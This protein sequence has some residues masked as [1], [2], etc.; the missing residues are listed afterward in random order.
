MH[1]KPVSEIFN[2]TGKIAL[3]T[4][5]SVGIGAGIAKRFADAGADIVFTYRTHPEGAETVAE[6]IKNLGR[7]V[8]P[9]K[10]DI[11]DP[12]QIKSL[13]EQIYKKW[14]ALDILINN[15]GI[16]P[17]SDILNMTL[18]EWEDMIDI[19]LRSVFLCTQAAARQM[20]EAKK[21]GAIVNIGSIEGVNPASGHSHYTASKAGVAMFGMTAALE[22]GPYHIRV[23]TVS[24]GLIN[25]PKLPTAWPEGVAR[26]LN[27]SPL[28]R[29]GEPEDIA[30]ACLFFAS[31]AARWITGTQLLVD[32]G[33]MTCQIY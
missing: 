18:E 12:L 16:F 30:D 24:P 33:V 29:L 13:F 32:G 6:I 31:D 15:A 23:N 9:I 20:V 11:A 25:S 1:M 27:R 7:K 4:G 19:N 28:G 14:G 22:L 2:F 10:V 26:F 5:G 21:G 3:V 8:M 17:H